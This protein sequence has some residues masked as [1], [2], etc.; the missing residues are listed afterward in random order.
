MNLGGDSADK[1]INLQLE[2]ANIIVRLVGD[3]SKNASMLLFS[4]LSDKDKNSNWLKNGAEACCFEIPAKDIKRFIHE[5]KGFGLDYNMMRDKSAPDSPAL[6]AVRSSQAHF[7]SS[8]IEKLNLNA[9]SKADVSITADPTAARTTEK[10]ASVPDFRSMNAKA[11]QY[12]KPT[13]KD[14]IRAFQQSKVVEPN[15]IRAKT[16]PL[17]K[18]R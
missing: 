5:A 3:L 10:G 17:G 1:L 2:S 16:I 13:V 12:S 9:V 7:A 14:R 11:E 18:D 6:I 4:Y 8:L 15:I